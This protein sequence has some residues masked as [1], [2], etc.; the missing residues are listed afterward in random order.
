MNIAVVS[1]TEKGRQLS[2]KISGLISE[3]HI[4]KRYCFNKHC[5]ENSENFCDIYKLSADIFDKYDAL[6]F[7]CACG[8]AVRSTAPHIFSKVSDPAVLVV[9]DCGRFVIPILSGHLGGANSLAEFVAKKIGAV[10]VIT[11][12]TDIGGNFS[13]DSFAKANNLIITD[14]NAAKDIAAAVLDNKKIGFCSK[15]PY[16]NL[17]TEIDAGTMHRLGICI[18]DVYEMPFE[19]TLNLV[20]KNIVAGIG[21]KRGTSCEAIEQHICNSFA[22]EK[23]DL[24]RICAVATIDI[25][26]DEKGLIE[27]CNKHS[28]KLYIY[29]AEELM[30]V[31]GDFNKSDFVLEQT[32]ADNV[33]ERS[34]VKCSEGTLI[35]HKKSAEGVTVAAAE[36]PTEIDFEKRFL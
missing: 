8:I 30:S 14:M 7:V 34:A 16:K 33:C 10:P 35:M 26:A 19:T 2:K 24:N 4:V 9:D 12:A 11:T 5:D 36:M 20:P 3:N 25:K 17:P 32:G 31:T 23:L 18:S 21:C 29:S 1:I 27:Y 28:L 22:A 13:P 15:Y 6:I